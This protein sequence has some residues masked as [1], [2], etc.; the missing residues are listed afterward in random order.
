MRSSC[1]RLRSRLHHVENSLLDQKSQKIIRIS[2]FPTA[3]ASRPH[4][5]QR[6]AAG[7]VSFK[8]TADV[9]CCWLGP[10]SLSSGAWRGSLSRVSKG[11]SSHRAKL[12]RRR[13]Y[14]IMVCSL[15]A[16]AAKT[17]L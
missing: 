6:R 5:P 12:E 7:R 1:N 14:L 17:G 4:V 15:C 8:L 3:P 11:F 9:I 13:P 16:A 2:P 10:D